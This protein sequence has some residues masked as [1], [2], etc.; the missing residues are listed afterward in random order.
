MQATR[1]HRQVAGQAKTGAQLTH[2]ITLR[3]GAQC[4]RRT[5]LVEAIH[6][7]VGIT[8]RHARFDYH[9]LRRLEAVAAD[10]AGG[11][12]IAV[13]TAFGRGAG[14]MAFAVVV[15]VAV[16]EAAVDKPVL[17]RPVAIQRQRV[18]LDVGLVAQVRMDVGIKVAVSHAQGGGVV[19]TPV[20]THGHAAAVGRVTVVTAAPILVHVAAQTL[21]PHAAGLMAFAL[22]GKAVEDCAID[23]SLPRQRHIQRATVDVRL[24]LLAHLSKLLRSPGVGEGL[25]HWVV[26]VE[27]AEHLL[28]ER[29][30]RRGR[31]GAG[32]CTG[33]FLLHLLV[34]FNCDDSLD[35]LRIRRVAQ[36]VEQR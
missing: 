8:R 5:F 22:V 15:V 6:A 31:C 27:P 23:N 33:K 36:H 24:E 9:G 35:R 1:A 11:Q 17:Q 10:H 26:L 28:L 21:H 13:V 18:A 2:F 32:T 4:G 14:H 30:H 7:H 19:Q 16:A 12:H 34:V 29:I 3:T 25:E 20:H